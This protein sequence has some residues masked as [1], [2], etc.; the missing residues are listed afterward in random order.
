MSAPHPPRPTAMTRRDLER[1]VRDSGLRLAGISMV[2]GF[3]PSINAAGGASWAS[4]V[5]RRGN[6]R[7]IRAHDGSSCVEVYAFADGVRLDQ[8]R[9]DRTT[10]AQ[11]EQIVELLA[12]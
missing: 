12:R 8:H 3:G 11:L 2:F 10:T 9:D 6:G 1:W 7:L 4:F 5:S